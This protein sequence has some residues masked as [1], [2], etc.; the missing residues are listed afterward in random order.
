MFNPE[1]KR[2][3]LLV[4]LC[5]LTQESFTLVEVSLNTGEG[6]ELFCPMLGTYGHRSFFI[7]QHLHPND[8][9]LSYARC[10][11]KEQLISVL[12]TQVCCD[13]QTPLSHS[14]YGGPKIK[15]IMSS[16]TIK[17]T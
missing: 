2:L 7:I 4:I 3:V 13:Q 5:M 1:I 11:A 17:I 16:I 12:I 8:P 10:L 14:H 9:Q 6:F 15:V